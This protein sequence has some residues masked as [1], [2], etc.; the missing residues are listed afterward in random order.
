MT[1]P[2]RHRQRRGPL[3]QLHPQ[4]VEVAEAGELVQ[5]AAVGVASGV[6]VAGG[7]VRGGRRAARAGVGGERGRRRDRAASLPSTGVG[8]LD[9]NSLPSVFTIAS[10]VAALGAVVLRDRGETAQVAEVGASNG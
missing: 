2:K 10:A 7:R 3:P 4:A 5:A 8:Q 6:A 1:L 9:S